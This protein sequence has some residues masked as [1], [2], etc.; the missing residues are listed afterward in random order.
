MCFQSGEVSILDANFGS[1]AAGFD[2]V[3][4]GLGSPCVSGIEQG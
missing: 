3:D 4:G 1:W 2:R